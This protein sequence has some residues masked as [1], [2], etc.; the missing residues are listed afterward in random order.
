MDCEIA[1]AVGI[2][3]AQPEREVY[4]MCGD[5]SFYMLHSEL[6]TALQEGAKINILLFDNASNGCINNLQMGN[7]IGSL[8]TEF[9]Y[10]S[11]DGGQNGP[12]PAHRLC[13]DRRGLRRQG[14]LGAQPRG[15]RGRPSGRQGQ[16][17]SCLIDMKV[18]PKT[19]TGDYL[20][21][22]H[23]GIASTSAKEGVQAAYARKEEHLKDARRY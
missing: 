3:L 9:R 1:G 6:V 12:L 22:W 2:K 19:M 4:A 8:G 15:A 10:R 16:S 13:Q 17:V 21:W 23:V 18:L 14:L 5:G 11:A 20:S 7:G